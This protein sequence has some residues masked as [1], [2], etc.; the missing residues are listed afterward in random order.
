MYRDSLISQHFGSILDSL[1]GI[2]STI[3]SQLIQ[4]D[5]KKVDY[6]ADIFSRIFNRLVFFGMVITAISNIFNSID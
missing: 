6:F 5:I 1:I 3:Y 4:L 2:I